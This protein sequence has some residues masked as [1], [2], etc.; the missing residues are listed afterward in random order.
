MPP[1][2]CMSESR[3]RQAICG[4][5][6]L[7]MAI[8]FR[9][10]LLPSSSMR[11]AQWWTRSRAASMSMRALA[12]S[13]ATVPCAAS[14]LPKATRET[15]R[16][17]VSSNA[18][19]HAPMAR[20][21]WW[22]RPGPRRACAI[23]KPRPWPR[24]IASVLSTTTS[25]KTHSAWPCGAS[26]KPRTRSGRSTRTR[27]IG[28]RTIEWRSCGAASSRTVAPTARP[29]KMATAQRGS[30]APEVHHLRPETTRCP[31]PSSRTVA[32]RFVGSD[33]A[34][35]GSVIAKHERISPASSGASHVARCAGVPNC[36]ST[37]M[38]PVSGAEQFITSGAHSDRPSSS[39]IGAYASSVCSPPPGYAADASW[40]AADGDRWA[41]CLS[42]PGGGAE[43][44]KRFQRP[45]A[46]ARALSA[47]SVAEGCHLSA[48]DVA[49]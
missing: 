29:M 41:S 19:S 2:I 26:S 6:T 39:Q 3:T 13:A 45:A 1:H 20:M 47:S 18:R 9:A 40:Y 5:A 33:D 15:T 4:T 49:P 43:R 32:S 31:S 21:Q 7:I 38:F 10:A 8:S 24:S 11:R 37:S 27:S 14:G 17:L 36:A 25:S 23:S 16:R 12:R 34:T 46:L 28:T 42:S 30:S 48:L 35:P 44:K 22:T